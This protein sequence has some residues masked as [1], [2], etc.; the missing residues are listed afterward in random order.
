MMK[1]ARF[2][3]SLFGIN[4]YVAYDE[5]TRECAI[6]DPGMTLPEE[7]AALDSFIAREKLTV[8]HLLNTH[9]H[10]DH[11]IGDNYVS[12]KYGVKV[13]AHPADEVLGERIDHQAEMFGLTKQAEGVHITHYLSDGDTIRIGNGE[14]KVLHV[15]GHSPGGIVLYDEKDGFLFAGDVLFA[16]SIGRTDL[17]GGSMTQLLTGIRE[18]LM[19]LPDSTIVYPGH[20]P[21]TTIGRERNSNLYLR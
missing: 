13:E 8:T 21:G 2:E 1:V 14:L 9:M 17:P 19:P 16:G 5:E 6:I 7:F 15:P 12:N 18:K 10:I 3:L 20:G 4:T 11:A